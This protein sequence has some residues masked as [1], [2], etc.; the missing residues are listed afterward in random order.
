MGGLEQQDKVTA[1]ELV[2]QGQAHTV[3]VAVVALERLESLEALQ[4]LDLVEMGFH[5]P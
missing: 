3:V 1:V 5:L 4:L 2:E